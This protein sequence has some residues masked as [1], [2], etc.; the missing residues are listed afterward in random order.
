MWS[1]SWKFVELKVGL[2]FEI[3]AIESTFSCWL[4]NHYALYGSDNVV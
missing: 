3:L 1:T 2:Y 4:L